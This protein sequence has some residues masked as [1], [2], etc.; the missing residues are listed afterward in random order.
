MSKPCFVWLKFIFCGVISWEILQIE[1]EK[2]RMV[3]ENCMFDEK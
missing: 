1:C 2:S 3:K